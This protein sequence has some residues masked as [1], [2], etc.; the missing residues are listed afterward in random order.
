MV[1]GTANS[2]DIGSFVG[3]R[4]GIATELNGV[5]VLMTEKPSISSRS[6]VHCMLRSVALPSQV[7]WF[8]NEREE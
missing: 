6:G 4:A 8:V 1:G 7:R 2:A 3:L 5:L